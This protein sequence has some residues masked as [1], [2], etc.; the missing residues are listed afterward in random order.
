MKKIDEIKAQLS[1]LVDEAYECGA[2]DKA[3]ECEQILESELKASYDKGKADGIKEALESIPTNPEVVEP[4]PQPTPEPEPEPS[5]EPEIVPEFSIENP[6]ISR[7][8]ADPSYDAPDFLYGDG[9]SVVDNYLADAVES[10]HQQSPTEQPASIPFVFDQL[11]DANGHEVE[12]IDGIYNL[13]PGC[14]YSYYRHDADWRMVL[15]GKFRTKPNTVRMIR[16]ADDGRI[17]NIRDLG[18]YKCEGGHVAY[19]KLLRSAWIPLELTA[20]STNIRL[21]KSLGVTREISFS[22]TYAARKALGWKANTYSGVKSYTTI[23]TNTSGILS[24]FNAILAEAQ[25]GGCSLMHCHTGADRTGS[26]SALLLALLGVSEAD[27]IKEWETT[28][29]SAMFYRRRISD[30]QT[31]AEDRKEC[32]EG[33][34]RQLFVKMRSIYGTKGETLQQQVYAFLTTKVGLSSAKITALKQA[35]I[36][37]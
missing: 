4:E 28:C 24:T 21:L 17:F 12:A 3:A 20:D 2:A 13:V 8:M 9:M 18:G 27:I 7:F 11:T 34:L 32:P 5:P 36:V 1:T 35:F 15:Q 31:R 37:H 10:G 16:T 30:W 19:G 26:V 25:A 23:L 22:S 6:W 29:F 14:E 33:Q